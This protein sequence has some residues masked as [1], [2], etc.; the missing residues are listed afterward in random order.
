MIGAFVVGLNFITV[1]NLQTVAV[2]LVRGRPPSA[3]VL[4]VLRQQRAPNPL[5][6]LEDRGT[7]DLLGGGRAPASSSSAR[8]WASPSSTSST[9]RTCSAT[10]RSRPG[11]AILPAVV[12]MVARRAP[13]REAGPRAGIAVRRCCSGQAVLGL[14]FIGMFF[15]WGEGTPLLDRGHPT[16][17]HGHRRRPRRHTVI[18]LADGLGPC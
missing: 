5:Y 14:A 6:D 2:G 17:P 11:A 10:T 3:L 16:R 15:L 1:P 9:S 13:L 18:Q 8:S 12:F 7:A 4:F